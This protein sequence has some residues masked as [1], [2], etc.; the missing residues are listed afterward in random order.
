MHYNPSV[1]EA[2]N[3]VEH[4][5]RDSTKNIDM[6]YRYNNPYRYDSYRIPGLCFTLWTNVIMRDNIQDV[7][8]L[9]ENPKDYTLLYFFKN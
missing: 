5:M 3:S 8:K 1:L 6:S 9:P 4:I 2:F 7:F